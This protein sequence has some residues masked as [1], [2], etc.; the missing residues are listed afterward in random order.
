MV[1]INNI[2]LIYNESISFKIL[3]KEKQ[4]FQQWHVFMNEKIA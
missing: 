1:F 4:C 2:D 3:E